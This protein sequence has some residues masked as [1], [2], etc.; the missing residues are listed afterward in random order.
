MSIKFL[1]IFEILISFIILP[2]I[3]KSQNLGLGNSLN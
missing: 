1:A 2:I 3:N